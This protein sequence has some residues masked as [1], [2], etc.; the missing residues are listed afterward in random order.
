MSTAV[1]RKNN[2]LTIPKEIMEKLGL[3]ENDVV[4][5]SIVDDAIVVK[6]KIVIEA[7]C[8]REMFEGYSTDDSISEEVDWKSPQGDEEW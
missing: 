6:P 3:H 2:R 1:I 5:I 7:M 8:V 4:D